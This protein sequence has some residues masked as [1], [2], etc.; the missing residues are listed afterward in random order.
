MALGKLDSA[1]AAYERAV[2]HETE[3]FFPIIPRYHFRLALV[4]EQAG[5]KQMAIEE[6]VK[7]LK[8]WRKADSIYKEPADARKRLARLKR[9]I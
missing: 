9:T 8:I 4:Y 1:I 3:P 7:F 2:S 5:M 6:Y